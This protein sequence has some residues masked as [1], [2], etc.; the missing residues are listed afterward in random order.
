[1]S[2]ADRDNMERPPLPLGIGSAMMAPIALFG[3]F[4]LADYP[5]PNSFT[6][7]FGWWALCLA[8]AVGTASLLRQFRK[9]GRYHFV[10]LTLCIALPAFCYALFYADMRPDTPLGIKAAFEQ[11]LQVIGFAAIGG[12]V[13]F[14]GWVVWKSRRA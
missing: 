13:A 1:M 2:L 3:T 10:F 8:V 11:S 12:V 14:I 7:Y 5:G 6:E 9:G 4:M